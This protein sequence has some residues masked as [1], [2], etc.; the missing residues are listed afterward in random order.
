[1][2]TF[3]IL[4]FFYLFW[5]HV[6]CELATFDCNTT[7]LTSA[8]T[9][10]SVHALMPGDIQAIGAIGDSLTVRFEIQL[11]YGKQKKR[12]RPPWLHSCLVRINQRLDFSGKDGKMKNLQN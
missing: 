12:C 2:K 9:P 10:Q 7:G 6:L 1:M 11:F 3:L 5:Q 4:Q 8:S